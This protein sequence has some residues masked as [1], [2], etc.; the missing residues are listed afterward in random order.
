MASRLETCNDASRRGT[1]GCGGKKRCTRVEWWRRKRCVRDGKGSMLGHRMQ[2]KG[3][4]GNSIRRQCSNLDNVQQRST[5]EG[6]VPSFHSVRLSNGVG[7][8][9]ETH[10][11]GP[12]SLFLCCTP[13]YPLAS[14]M[15][16]FAISNTCCQGFPVRCSSNLLASSH[17]HYDRECAWFYSPVHINPSICVLRDVVVQGMSCASRCY[18]SL[19]VHAVVRRIRPRLHT[20]ST[21]HRR[22]TITCRLQKPIVSTRWRHNSIRHRLANIRTG[23]GEGSD[24]RTPSSCAHRERGTSDRQRKRRRRCLLQVSGTLPCRRSP[25][26][27]GRCSWSPR[28]EP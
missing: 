18:P 26:R 6:M 23:L 25:R 20:S 28:S 9:R 3:G 4:R 2:N 24:R 13:P 10:F 27:V 8:E 12:R 11:C 17:V 5:T 14:H 22:T 1:N 21:P 16:S 19:H 7:C 15:S